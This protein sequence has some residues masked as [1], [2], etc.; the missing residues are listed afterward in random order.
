MRLGCPSCNQTVDVEPTGDANSAQATCPDCGAVF[1]WTATTAPAVITPPAAA[2]PPE[3]PPPP[4]PAP[5]AAVPEAAAPEAE[6][7]AP[8]SRGMVIV[9][10][11][12]PEILTAYARALGDAGYAVTETSDG[13]SCL[14]LMSQTLP[15]AAVIDGGLPPIFGMGLGEII[16][17]SAVTAAI[18]VLGLHRDANADLPVPGT[19]RT[20]ALIAGADAVVAEVAVL[21][22]GSASSAPAPEAPAPEAAAPP[23]PAP[24][25]AAP[26]PPA[27]EAAAPPPPAPEVAAPPPPAPEAAAPPPPA[28]EAAAP[29][30]PPAPEAAAPPPPPAPEA[31]APPPP[32]APEAAAPPPPAA[33]GVA[34]KSEAGGGDDKAHK[35]AQRLARIIVSDIALYNQAAIDE[36][37]KNGNL[38]EAMGPFLDEGIA[39]YKDKTP[40]DIQSSTDYLNEALANFIERKMKTAAPAA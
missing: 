23:P 17:K 9:A 36:G 7:P 37:I 11:E 19:E 27:P 2:A 13:R 10:I 15:A 30:P 33:D 4:P 21:I 20:V 28:P 12:K 35:A 22:E 39:H 3:P 29:P 18:P 25:V 5:E 26:P 40:E 32:P 34:S 16:K 31:A 38:R 24:E 8:G 14:E 6:A 1:G